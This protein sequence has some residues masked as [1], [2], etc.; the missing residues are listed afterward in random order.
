LREELDYL[1][2]D[3]NYTIGDTESEDSDPKTDYNIESESED[4]NLT[5]KSQASSF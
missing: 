2:V 1:N 4:S 5:S 3:D